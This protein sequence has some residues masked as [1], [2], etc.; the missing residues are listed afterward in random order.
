MNK[1][2][3][4]KIKQV[5]FLLCIF[6]VIMHSMSMTYYGIYTSSWESIFEFSLGGGLCQVA[7][8]SFYLIS[9]YLF[10]WN[11]DG[12]AS[13]SRK[14][15]SKI[16]SLVVPYLVWNTIWEVY[17]FALFQL[18]ISEKDFTGYAVKDFLYDILLSTN[19]AL[20]FVKWLI[21]FSLI[22]PIIYYV[23]KHK[24]L[25]IALEVL[26]ICTV[27][28][29]KIDYFT[30]FYW[31]PMYMFGGYLGIHHEAVVNQFDYW[32]EHRKQAVLQIVNVVLL[33]VLI[34]CQLIYHNWYT[35][36]FLRHIGAISFMVIFF[37]LSNMAFDYKIMQYSFPIYCVHVPVCG[38]I[39]HFIGGITGFIVTPI[40][41]IVLIYLILDIMQKYIPSVYGVLFGKRNKR[42]YTGA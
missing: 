36:F 20:W 9:A 37:L 4:L 24:Y 13:I 32:F 18:G 29:F 6:I 12:K 26:T 10:Y 38:V 15:R 17:Y 30:P 7:V 25:F 5:Q 11:C 22:S 33:V 27:V 28:L 21:L 2:I 1:K 14:I 40:L 8:P 16:Q 23:I 34:L 39:K 3:S 19:T 42:S 41:T 31:L 35:Y